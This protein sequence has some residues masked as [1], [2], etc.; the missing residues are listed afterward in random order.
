MPTLFSKRKCLISLVI[1]IGSISLL[2]ALLPYK[3]YTGSSFGGIGNP[4]TRSILDHI[5]GAFVGTYVDFAFVSIL[6]PLVIL[7]EVASFGGYSRIW[8][9]F[10]IQGVLLL[11]AG[12]EMYWSMTFYF[13]ESGVRLLPTFYLALSWVG[14]SAILSCLLIVPAVRNIINRLVT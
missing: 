9:F 5:R 6:F 12:L 8:R 13:L 10:A 2:L 4:G 1:I 14:L 3:S 11:C 7:L